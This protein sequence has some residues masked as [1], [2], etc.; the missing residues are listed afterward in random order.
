MWYKFNDED[1]SRST[2]SI[3]ATSVLVVKKLCMAINLVPDH[4]IEK[5][6]E[7]HI[8]FFISEKTEATL[9]EANIVSTST[10]VTNEMATKLVLLHAHPQVLVPLRV[11]TIC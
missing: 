8:C 4:D 1:V 2:L 5:K 7:T 10:T 9:I 6:V 3:W 11:T